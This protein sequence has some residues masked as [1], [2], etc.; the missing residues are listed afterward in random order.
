MNV[1]EFLNVY[2]KWESL[3][4][5][6]LVFISYDYVV[7]FV[8]FIPP[9]EHILKFDCVAHFKVSINACVVPHRDQVAISSVPNFEVLDFHGAH[10][11]YWNISWMSDLWMVNIELVGIHDWVCHDWW[12]TY[13]FWFY[14]RYWLNLD[15]GHNFK[16][17]ISV[18]NGGYTIFIANSTNLQEMTEVATSSS[19]VK[20]S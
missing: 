6:N 19:E 9:G 17:Y 16:I 13:I 14:S 20:V 10:P 5:L 4:Y 7:T 2:L 3:T 12:F 1:V 15:M 11:V 18:I 8:E